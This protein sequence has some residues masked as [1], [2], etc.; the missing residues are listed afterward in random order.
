MALYATL[1]AAAAVPHTTMLL[2]SAASSAVQPPPRCVM[3][4]RVRRRG[5]WLKLAR[6]R[7]GQDWRQNVERMRVHSPGKPA[8]LVLAPASGV[9]FLSCPYCCLQAG[10][11]KIVRMRTRPVPALAPPKQMQPSFAESASCARAHRKRSNVNGLHAATSLRSS[12]RAKPQQAHHSTP[13][14]AVDALLYWIHR[15]GPPIRRS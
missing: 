10:L 15:E 9:A 8:A 6:R 14:D 1:V 3:Y 11:G 5:M 12:F 7:H 2:A 13:T 4:W